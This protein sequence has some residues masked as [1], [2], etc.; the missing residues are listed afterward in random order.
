MVIYP[1]LS[2]CSRLHLRLQC[3]RWLTISNFSSIIKEDNFH[4]I[5]MC[6]C[7]LLEFTSKLTQSLL[8][9]RFEQFWK[10]FNLFCNICSKSINVQQT[11]WTKLFWEKW[12]W[13]LLQQNLNLNEM[14][15]ESVIVS[16]SHVGQPL[17]ALEQA[18]IIKH[19][20]QVR[21]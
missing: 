13:S 1:Y 10:I 6:I 9:C 19:L 11:S 17:P 21:F 7:D 8:I 20:Q 4:L 12:L 16:V 3:K 2:Y 18:N 5:S 15:W 14:Y